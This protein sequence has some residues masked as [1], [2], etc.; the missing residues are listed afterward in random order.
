MFHHQPSSSRVQTPQTSTPHENLLNR[1][2]RLV[3]QLRSDPVGVTERHTR[4]KRK[5]SSCTISAE[6]KIQRKLVII[7][8]PGSSPSEVMVLHEYEKIF[9]GCITF[10]PSIPE[11]DLRELI[12]SLVQEKHKHSLFHNLCDICPMDFEFVRVANK[13]VRKPDGHPVFNGSGVKDIYGRGSIYVRLTKC[14]NK[15]RTLL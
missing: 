12:C 6:K 11:D 2:S 14:V 8:Y 13:R 3:N 9:D 7:D 10:V 5:R 15:V 4:R 1:A